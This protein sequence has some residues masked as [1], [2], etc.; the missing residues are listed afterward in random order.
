MRF[1]CKVSSFLLI[2]ALIFQSTHT[3]VYAI[4]S[5]EQNEEANLK[6]IILKDE[7]E[8][9][10]PLLEEE[11]D[12]SKVLKRLQH[13]EE[14]KIL[15]KSDKYTYVEYMNKESGELLQGFILTDYLN[16]ID[17]T[18]KKPSSTES[19]S[20]DKDEELEDTNDVDSGDN[21]I[22]ENDD[23]TQSE[24]GNDDTNVVEPEDDR[25][26]DDSRDESEENDEDND[27]ESTDDEI[28]ESSENQ[29][30]FDQATED[31]APEIIEENIIGE[32][33]KTENE[34]QADSEDTDA[35]VE[36]PENKD[37]NSL[38]D[39]PVQQFSLSQKKAEIKTVNKNQK[40]LYGIALK[41]PTK[42][43]QKTSTSA[44]VLKS[45]AQGS[46]LK[47]KSYSSG[48]YE[49]SVYVNGKYVTGYINK[50]DVEEPTKSQTTLY[51]IGLKSPTKV[52]QKTSTGAKV[53]KSYKS[54]SI[55]KYKTFTSDWYEATVY[56][57][58]KPNTGYIHKSHVE[59]PVK[60]QINLK[61]IGL[62][63][64]TTV[65]ASAST[66]STKLK[67][68][69]QG[70]VLYYK[71]FSSKWYEAKVY[72]N[73]KPTTGYIH[74]S[75]VE[76]IYDSHKTLKGLASK[77]PTK[78]YARASQGASVLK[79]YSRNSFLKYETF[80]PNWYRATV[81]V[82]G[83]KR[84]GY[85]H[86]KDVNQNDVVVDNTKYKH[87]FNDVL[88]LQMTRSPQVWKNG[89]FVD[90]SRDQVSYYLNSSNFRPNTSSYFQFLNLSSPAG[91]NA[92]EINSKVLHN[93]GTLTGTAHAFIQAGRTYNVNEIYLMAHALH[94]TGNGRSTLAEGVPVDKNGN[95]VSKSKAA[96][97]VYNMY[98]YGAIDSDPLNGGAKYAFNN[99]WFT[100]EAAIIGGAK[101][102][103]NN[104]INSGQNTLY[105]MR[106]N[107]ASPGYPQY[108]TDVAW[109]LA[110]TANIS[111]IYDSISN[112]VLVYDVP[113]YSNQPASSGDPNKYKD[114]RVSLEVT[115]TSINVRSG[116]GTSYKVVGGVRKGNVLNAVLDKNNNI[117]KRT[118]NG[119]IWY[120]IH[121]NSSTAWV[122]GGK[123]GTEYIRVK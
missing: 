37:S 70:T 114:S 50:N 33:N 45:Y 96:H 16:E 38:A 4:S 77:S 86:A 9:V 57:N 42:V 36:E 58:G 64:P 32:E 11:S 81:Y 91:V 35:E 115:T 19:D 5:I 60:N 29:E 103:A 97:T 34:E 63:S 3:S 10:V 12:S 99:G 112:Y 121:F 90:A 79:T 93:A 27:S 106:W 117:V 14:V 84:T 69:S 43:H 20:M 59:V 25:L 44:K 123:N 39:E 1:I 75:H 6:K 13:E 122:S 56:I 68:Y 71:T 102:I 94:E 78:V 48:W 40:T 107:P 2:F 89:T 15:K 105:K 54:G 17:A 31:A 95:V 73:G 88:D 100:P 116:A 52:Y 53:L 67:S 21:E 62:K 55:L 109:A 18:H 49:A 7:I 108:A 72:L 30:S 85:I 98:G 104:Y 47:Y 24:K 82:N 74:V 66:N 8:E 41:S 120:Q 118:A 101:D 83:K 51:G 26:I 119:H 22:G 110:Q 46:K 111:K 87:N 113:V 80:S 28:G 61:G 65:Y 92:N 23:N 76:E